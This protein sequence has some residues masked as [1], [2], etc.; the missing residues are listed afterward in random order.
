[1]DIQY[2]IIKGSCYSVECEVNLHLKAGWK[3]SGSLFATG[4]TLIEG[5]SYQ[6]QIESKEV[7]QAMVVDT[8][9]LNIGDKNES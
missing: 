9:L 2:K 1:M 3:L 6:L 4:K 8:R 7:A 5:S